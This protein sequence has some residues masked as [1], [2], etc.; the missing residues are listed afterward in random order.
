MSAST[1]S[2][3]TPGGAVG[4]L[5]DLTI[6]RASPNQP[7]IVA[8]VSVGA[9]TVTGPNGQRDPYSGPAYPRAQ[10]MITEKW[11]GSDWTVTDL[12]FGH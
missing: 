11:T 7:V 1:R 8:N 9:L 3:A 2:L 12:L 4:S 10:F 6:S 5:K